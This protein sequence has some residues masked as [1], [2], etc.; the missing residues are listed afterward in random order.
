VLVG[1]GDPQLLA[2]GAP[3]LAGFDAVATELRDVDVFQLLCEIESGA[4]CEMLP[5]ALHPT[6]P[7][8]VSFG[9]WQVGESPW[10]SFR[11]AWTRLEC[12]SGLR[13]RGLWLRGIIDNAAAAKGL[14]AG[15]GY[16]LSSGSVEFEHRYDSVRVR[17]T[18]GE[19]GESG[20]GEASLEIGLR[21]PEPLGTSD[22]QYVSG[23]HPTHTPRGYRLLQVDHAHDLDRAERG[24][25]F[26]ERFDA[27]AFG[28]PRIVPSHPIAAS[29][30]HG[31]VTLEALRFVC[32]P[33]VL[34]FM[35]TEPAREA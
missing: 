11:L 4:E 6:N 24:K 30:G 32:R 12:R 10:G 3:E 27:A 16:R 33:D 9:A 13:P 18:P 29:L 5:P 8:V 26:V 17:A 22:I 21:D 34:A 31:T 28:E 1:T 19:P 35:G 23:V 14:A 25:A 2:P 20:P 7:P 15:W